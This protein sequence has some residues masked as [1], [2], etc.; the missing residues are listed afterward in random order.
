MN[1]HQHAQMIK[2]SQKKKFFFLK[3]ELLKAFESL[4]LVMD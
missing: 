3:E 1:L 4:E 2:I